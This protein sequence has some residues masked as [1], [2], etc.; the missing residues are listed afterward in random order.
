MSNKKIISIIIPCF[1]EQGYLRITVDR[2]VKN[3][4][5]LDYKFE[6]IIVDDGSIDNTT[7]EITKLTQSSNYSSFIIKGIILSKNFGHQKALEAGIN[8]ASGDAVIS[9]D[10]DLEQ[11]P[12]LLPEL[13]T[14]WEKGYDIVYTIRENDK[15]LSLLKRITSKGFYKVYNFLTGYKIE[16]G[17]ADYR[18]LD[19]K[20]VDVF[21][22]MPEHNKF[23]RGIIDWVGFKKI[24][25]RYKSTSIKNRNSRYTLSKMVN[26]AL[27]GIISFSPRPLYLSFVIGLVTLLFSFLYSIIILYLYLFGD[28]SPGQASILITITFFT[29]IIMILLGIQGLYISQLI[30]EV[31]N[32]PN[33]IVKN[34]IENNI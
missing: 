25:I 8:Y 2:V 4:K 15:S 6:L 24:P 10:A 18:L 22:S 31:K 34:I 26:L 28:T 27:N 21:N 17:V 32:R 5:N 11:P 9:I 3:I 30:D 7:N 19:K 20:V 1:N 33:F 16:Q 12:E 29:S 14:F 23:I 13:I